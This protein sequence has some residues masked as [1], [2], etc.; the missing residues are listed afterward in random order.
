ML[1]LELS[2]VELRMDNQY[3]FSDNA[4]ECVYEYLWFIW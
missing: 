3:Y 4:Y 2:A 1:I